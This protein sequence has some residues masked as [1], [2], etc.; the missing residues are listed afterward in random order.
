MDLLLIIT[1][2]PD[3]RVVALVK[4]GD[5]NQEETIFK[6][7][8]EVQNR[9]MGEHII[10]NNELPTSVTAALTRSIHEL[11]GIYLLSENRHVNNY[12]SLISIRL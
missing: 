2:L 1:V 5:K 7:F 11:E 10:N 6:C 4:K 9:R 3:I 8:V 12:F